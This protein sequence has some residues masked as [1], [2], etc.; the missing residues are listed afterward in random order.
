MKDAELSKDWD[1]ANALFK[2]MD[3]YRYLKIIGE[4]E[5]VVADDGEVTHDEIDVIKNI[6]GAK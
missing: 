6:M 2:F 4:L 1:D 5:D 3:R